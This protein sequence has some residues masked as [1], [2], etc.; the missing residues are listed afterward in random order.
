MAQKLP[1]SALRKTGYIVLFLAT[2][3]VTSTARGEAEEGSAG[4]KGTAGVGVIAFPKYIGGKQTRV[5]PIP[6]LSINYND[7]FY[8]ELQRAGVYL[9]ASNDKKL[10]LG[11]AVEPRFGYAGKDGTLL[12]GM[13]TRRDSLEGGPTFDWDFDVVAI[14]IAWFGDLDRSSRGKSLRTAVYVPILKNDFWD[15][16]ALLAA[17]RMNG[18]LADYYFGVPATEAN[19]SRPQYRAGAGTHISLGLSGTYRL[20]NRHALMFGWNA[21]RLSHGARNSPLVEAPRADLFYLGYGWIL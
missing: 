8:I 3:I 2:F 5:L 17:D 1:M 6:L 21:T 16:G 7:T 15:A 19:A 13:A 20:H 10:G 9:L 14:S 11:L 18:R 4:W 12:T